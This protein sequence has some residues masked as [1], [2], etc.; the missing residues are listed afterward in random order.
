[1]T[2]H[3]GQRSPD[4]IE[5]DI[6][7]TRHD[8]DATLSALEQRLTP[9]Q[10]MDQGLAYLRRSGAREYVDR[11]GE[12]AKQDPVPLAL[13]G[14]GLAWLMWSERGRGRSGDAEPHGSFAASAQERAASIADNAAA[15]KDGV[16]RASH[17]VAG[18]AHALRERAGRLGDGARERAA[19]AIDT[20]REQTERV[21]G[22]YR[23]L[24]TEQP[25][26]L[27][28]VGLALGAVLA[29]AA[30]RTRQEDRVLGPAREGLQNDLLQAAHDSIDAAAR[31]ASSAANAAVE[32]LHD[33]PADEV[34]PAARPSPARDE[35]G[36]RQADWNPA[37]TA[38][39]V[40]PARY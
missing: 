37:T 11:L 6:E 35:P 10:L 23:Q 17:R 15:M 26:V 40:P 31:A 14:V 24:T 13:V 30:P 7:R 38:P 4:Q 21:R 27:G 28:A 1:M 18:T 16:A 29:A 25:L 33:A 12:T 22:G 3:N 32:T 8:L 9:G 39:P 2:R 36:K 20:A 34:Q 19:R 5:A